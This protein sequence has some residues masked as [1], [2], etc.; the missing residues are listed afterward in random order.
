MATPSLLNFFLVS[1]T[2]Q[3]I[4]RICSFAINL[5]LLR[6]VDAALLGLV[7]VRLT[8]LYTTILFLVREPLRKTCLSLPVKSTPRYVNHLWL[9]P[10]TCLCISIPLVPLWYYLA[11]GS[12]PTEYAHG[13]LW[14]VISFVL[15]AFIECIAEPFAIISQKTGEARHFAFA[16][17]LLILSQRLF[18]L[19]LIRWAVVDPLSGFCLAQLLSSSV[20]LGAHLLHFYKRTLSQ[21]FTDAPLGIVSFRN[22]FPSAQYGLDKSV[23]KQIGSF[24]VHSIFKQLLTDGSGFVMTFS[25]TIGLANQAVYDAIE[26]LGSL[27]AR[28]VLAPLEE[29]SY[30]YFSNEFERDVAI[31]NQPR[32]KV[33]NGVSTLKNL[34][35]GTTLLSSGIIVFGIA[36]SRLAV[37]V[38]GGELLSKNQGGA[39]LSCYLGYLFVMAVN[40]ITECF[41]AATMSNSDI[42]AHIGF[43]FGCAFLHI[44]M[45]IACSF[46]FAAFGFILANSIN[47]VVRIVYSW[48]HIRQYLGKWTPALLDMVPSTST[49]LLLVF[50]LFVTNLS[51]LIFGSTAGIVHNGAHIAIGGVMFLVVALNIYKAEVLLQQF[52][53]RS[54]QHQD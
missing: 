12:V 22:Y 7:N 8:L 15:S 35:R 19:V 50:S 32:A 3:L 53:N 46:Y 31:S 36:Y 6:T 43:L 27:V 23:L 10:I 29:S 33:S 2:G 16:Q 5:Y 54:L 40:G 28:I 49:I 45:N 52:V 20:Y 24:L 26:K 42:F 37:G 14:V 39:L 18:A 17:S 9:A 21:S 48:Q 4:S 38:Y 30:L 1:L 11:S 51:N 13:Y 25:N 41:A 34:L 44:G 47:M